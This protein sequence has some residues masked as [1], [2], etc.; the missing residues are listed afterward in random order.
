MWILHSKEI[1]VIPLTHLYR[2]IGI[3]IHLNMRTNLGSVLSLFRLL[4][5][6]SHTLHLYISALHI[7]VS[8]YLYHSFYAIIRFG[9][10]FILVAECSVFFCLVRVLLLYS[11]NANQIRP[12][13]VR[14]YKYAG[15]YSKP[16]NKYES[17]ERSEFNP[18]VWF[19]FELDAV[20]S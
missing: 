8:V 5:L 16:C 4:P 15:R 11:F 10:R 13:S 2:I 20:L 12:I 17:V 9:S 6:V 18:N 7:S 1:V 14:V 3:N 19:F